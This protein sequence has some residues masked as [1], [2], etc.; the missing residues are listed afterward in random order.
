MHPCSRTLLQLIPAVLV[1]H[2]CS[3]YETRSQISGRVSGAVLEGVEVRVSGAA[4]ATTT[5]SSTGEFRFED[6]PEGNYSITASK[7]GY[8]F[9][10]ASLGVRL[11]G[12]NVSGRD[13]TGSVLP[14]GQCSLSGWCWRNP[15]P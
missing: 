3:S 1:A 9:D 10:P 11:R 12:E 5:T 7:Q 2:G 4:S 6:M 13:F 8:V 15:L 14:D